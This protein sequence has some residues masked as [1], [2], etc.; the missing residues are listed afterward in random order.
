ME[1][2]SGLGRR[3]ELLHLRV[4]TSLDGRRVITVDGLDQFLRGFEEAILVIAGG[5]ERGSQ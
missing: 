4:E 3:Q 5:P 2:G 1:E